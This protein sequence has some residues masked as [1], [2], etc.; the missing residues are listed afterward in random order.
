MDILTIRQ[1]ITLAMKTITCK[2]MITIPE[3]MITNKDPTMKTNIDKKSNFEIMKVLNLKGQDHFTQSIPNKNQK[4]QIFHN[5]KANNPQSPYLRN[6]AKL[7]GKLQY[8]DKGYNQPTTMIL[9]AKQFC[10]S[11]YPISPQGVPKLEPTL[12]FL[13]TS[14]PSRNREKWQ[15]QPQLLKISP[16]NAPK[17]TRQVQ[18]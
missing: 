16:Q 15:M 2:L 7:K 13:T 8:T 12:T 1:S 3:E 11:P 5:P 6:Y 14:H 17:T 10:Q 4:I 18:N 9:E